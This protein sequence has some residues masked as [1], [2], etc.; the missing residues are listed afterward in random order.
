LLFEVP[1]AARKLRLALR[2]GTCLAVSTIDKRSPL[3]SG[4]FAR[5]KGAIVGGFLASDAT[6][7]AAQY[8]ARIGVWVDPAKLW[9][10]IELDSSAL[11]IGIG[12]KDSSSAADQV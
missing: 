12:E 3:P 6:N 7:L 2:T 11:A 4:M 1:N 8:A 5:R 10:P 9:S